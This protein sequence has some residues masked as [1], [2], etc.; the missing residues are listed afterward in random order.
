MTAANV[1]RQLSL[2]ESTVRGWK[3]KHNALLESVSISE[4]LTTV[5]TMT[6]ATAETLKT[7]SVDNSLSVSVPLHAET[8]RTTEH[9]TQQQT[10]VQRSTIT[11][12][13]VTTPVATEAETEKNFDIDKVK[14]I[15]GAVCIFLALAAIATFQWSLNTSVFEFLGQKFEIYSLQ[16]FAWVGALGFCLGG[17]SLAAFVQTDQFSDPYFKGVIVFVMIDGGLNTLKLVSFEKLFSN[18]WQ[19]HFL[20]LLASVACPYIFYYLSKMLF[21]VINNPPK[22]Q[23]Y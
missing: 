20:A 23:S 5:D 7:V 17:F 2:N 1:A 13:I 18:E 21:S 12:T 16:K 9:A 22:L 10:T 8:Q 14:R 15:V 3:F 6:V 11:E 19:L 4:T